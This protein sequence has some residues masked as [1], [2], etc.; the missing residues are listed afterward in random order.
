MPTNPPPL[1]VAWISDFGIEWLPELPA[2]L[3]S[4][5]RQHPMTWQQVL[6]AELEPRPD[7]EIHI[8]VLRKGIPAGLSFPQGRVTF[9]VLRTRGGWR[10]PS[11]FWLDTVLIRRRL[12]SLAPAV[13]HAWG[14]ERGAALV[15]SRMSCPY[16][17]TIQGLLTWYTQAARLNAYH[18]FAAG[19]EKVSLRRARTVTTESAFAVRFLQERYPRLTV[20]QIE[21]ASNWA[22]HRLERQPQTSP[23]RFVC[24]GTLGH[25]K[26]TDL[27]LQAFHQLAGTT[28][29][30]LVII[31]GAD[32]D[33]FVAPFRKTLPG[34]LWK[35]VSFRDQLPTAEVVKELA[36]A[37]LLV[38]PTRAD[39]SPN[40]VKEAAVAGVPVVASA[41]GGIPDYIVPGKN[42]LLFPPGDLEG[43]VRTLKEACAHPLFSRGRVD[44]ATL[45]RTRDYLSPA[46]MGTRFLELYRALAGPPAA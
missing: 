5:P 33:P 42:G 39:T 3:R 37:T 6:L 2:A 32:T 21:H 29:F 26:G 25:R 36:A 24:V 31:G 23:P 1:K 38:L 45:A 9:H 34:E 18:R 7:L 15:A 35:R 44:D 14:T 12:R 30:E 28:P 10:A 41:V 4:L 20:H 11:L 27:L 8:L 17:V 40:A 22:Y 43:L 46:R 16:L 19:L 13:V